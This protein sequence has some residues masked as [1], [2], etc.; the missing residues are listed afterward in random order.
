M[1]KPKVIAVTGCTATGKSALALKL[2]QTLNGEIICMDSMQVYCRM[3][4][5]TAKPTRQEQQLVPHHL[6]DILEPTEP[7]A[8]SDY[9]PL[10]EKAIMEISARNRVAL[11]VGGTGL[12]LKSLTHGMTLGIADSDAALRAKY[13]AMAEEPDGKQKLHELLSAVD[14]EAANRLHPND[15]RRVI[16]ALEIFERTGAPMSKQKQQEPERPYEI[17]TL[18]LQMPRA[19]LFERI[20]K[21]IDAMLAQG[22][23]QEV[24]KLLQSGVSPEAQS[25]QGIGYKEL[26]PVAQGHLPLEAARQQL[27]LNTRHFAKRQETWFKREE[28]IQW[29]TAGQDAFSAVLSHCQTFLKKEA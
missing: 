11:L 26:V 1:S 6:L 21:R 22:L 18:G 23:L 9:V 19:L 20:E 4:V 28:A 10:A 13:N 7:F 25:M 14:P 27:I 5:G 8:V 2:A 16:R 29:S 24:D 17:L 12:Y 3:D 15:L